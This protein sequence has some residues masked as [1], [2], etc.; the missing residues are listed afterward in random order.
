MTSVT[1]TEHERKYTVDLT[2]FYQWA[3]PYIT[4]N[5]FT[6][7]V[8]RQW[9]VPDA[10][11]NGGVVRIR[12]TDRPNGEIES[13]ELTIKVPTDD[14]AHRAEFN[15]IAPST[16]DVTEFVNVMKLSNHAIVKDRWDISR[17]LL[18]SKQL[19]AN[20]GPRPNVVIDF[21][22]EKDGTTSAILEIENPPAD[23]APPHFVKDDVTS[24]MT[25]TNFARAAGVFSNV[26][27]N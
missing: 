22:G 13:V 26:A 10:L 20:G 17:A 19:Q 21:F 2:A 23:W 7:R 12:R 24:N 14:P 25:Y 5:I 18:D 6:N 3:Q 16:F 9:Y 11:A 1:N 15:F 27:P 8:I 4:R